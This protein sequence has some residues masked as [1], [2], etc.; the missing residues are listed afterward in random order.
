MALRAVAIF[1]STGGIRYLGDTTIEYLA[2]RGNLDDVG[3]GAVDGSFRVELML[4]Y[5]SARRLM[6]DY[7]VV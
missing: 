1:H 5:P 4:I 2:V 3:I 6:V 7:P